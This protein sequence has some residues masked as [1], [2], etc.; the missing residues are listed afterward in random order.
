MNRALHRAA[1]RLSIIP[2]HPVFVFSIL[3]PL[4]LL[5]LAPP[6]SRAGQQP[7]PG[8]NRSAQQ[9]LVEALSAACRQNAQGFSRFLLAD[10]GRAFDSLPQAEQ[11]L[12]LERFSLTSMPGH[13]R[14]LLDT[15]GHIAV[16]CRT[17]AETVDFGLGPA[18]IDQNVAFL[19]VAVTGGETATF[20][21][22]RQPEGWRLFSLDLLVINVPALVRQWQNAEMQAN[23][24][25][26]VADLFHIAQAI[27]TFHSSFGE[28]P[29]TLEQ[30]GP[31]PPNGVSPEHAQ[32][33][34]EKIASGT[35]DGYRFRFRVVTDSHGQVR[36]FEL[37]AVP[38]TYGKTGRR[39]FFLDDQGKLHA[40][41]RQ[42][43]PATASDPVI[44]PPAQPSSE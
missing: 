39:S 35:T 15:Q 26:A 38:E 10:S 32:L 2:G 11:K 40:A 37:G 16:Q 36:G 6:A 21:L 22:V 5:L 7:P 42:G 14:A 9:T 8:R 18:K 34:P 12:F 19:P 31:A 44:A 17:P 30:L 23:E 28:W 13:P 41:D 4:I 3:A 1:R 20:G 27:Q 43:A 33:L 24:A 29:N 25:E